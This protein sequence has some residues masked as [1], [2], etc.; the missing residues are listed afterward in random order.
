M[1]GTTVG[2]ASLGPLAVVFIGALVAV[3]VLALVLLLGSSAGHS[4]RYFL[5]ADAHRYQDIAAATG[6]PY[7]DH[8]VEVPPGGLAVVEL[9]TGSTVRDTAVRLGW[10]QLVI[11]LAIAAVV[12]MGWGAAAVLSYLVV[13]AVLAPFVYFRIDLLSVLL[14][15]GAMALA[16]R[17]RERAGGTLLGLSVFTK[18]WPLALVP[19]LLALGK[20]RSAMWAGAVVA[21]GTV[22]WVAWAGPKG[23]VQVAT[24]RSANGWQIESVVGSVVRL[25]SSARPTLDQGAWRIGTIPLWA[26]LLLATATLALLGLA[27]S[28]TNARRRVA[29]GDGTTFHAAGVAGT[30][31]LAAVSA[32]LVCSPLLSMQYVTWLFPWVAIAVARGEQRLERVALLVTL[33]STVTIL[34]F[35]RLVQGSGFAQAVLLCRNASLVFLV[36]L[37]FRALLRGSGTLRFGGTRTLDRPTGPSASPGRG[38]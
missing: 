35:D 28:A 4:D 24:F 36:V 23:L 1:A 12:F 14:A 13:G 3:R 22:A 20:R 6:T 29:G 15:T 19:V 16:V 10:S 27:W 7:R 26:E 38:R 33:L 32:V 8:E 34:Q 31:S 17:R 25:F 5:L 2:A 9:V 11:D 21:A 37:S 30:A 18:V